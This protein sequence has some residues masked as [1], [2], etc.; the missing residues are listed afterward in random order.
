MGGLYNWNEAMKYY[1]TPGSQGICPSGWHVPTDEEFKILEGYADSKYNIGESI[2]D[3]TGARGYDAGNLLR[4]TWG[5]NYPGLDSYGFSAVGTGARWCNGYLLGHYSATSLWT[6][7]YAGQGWV[8]IRYLRG[9][10]YSGW[11]LLIYHD[12]NQGCN[13]NPVRCLK[14]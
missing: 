1:Y 10:S 6:S 12:Q 2:W 7:S 13:G 8:W 3:G 5:F 4:A 14:D 11:N 9:G